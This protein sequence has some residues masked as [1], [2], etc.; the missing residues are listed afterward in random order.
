LRSR[1]R[2]TSGRGAAD[3]GQRGEAVPIV[4]SNRPEQRGDSQTAKPPGGQ[5]QRL[6]LH[7][8]TTSCGCRN[9]DDTGDDDRRPPRPAKHRGFRG[10]V[11][12]PN[13]RGH[14]KI[15]RRPEVAQCEHGHRIAATIVQFALHCRLTLRFQNFQ[16]ATWSVF[17][18]YADDE[19]PCMPSKGVEVGSVLF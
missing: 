12:C 1:A 9:G 11:R 8:V 6:C 15:P 10:S 14:R 16:R 18:E 2:R 19:A 13:H 4:S 3:R 5:P 17:I 7:P